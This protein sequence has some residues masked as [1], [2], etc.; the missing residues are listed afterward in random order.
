VI[1]EDLEEAIDLLWRVR[2]VDRDGDR[3]HAGAL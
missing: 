1:A 2:D 3:L